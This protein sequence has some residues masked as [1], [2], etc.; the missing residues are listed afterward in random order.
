MEDTGSSSST[1]RRKNYKKSCHCGIKSSIRKA[2]TDKNPGRLFYGCDRYQEDGCNFFEWYDDG[3]VTGWPK[4]S[5]L[6][7]RDELRQKDR[8]I[9]RLRDRV[10]SLEAELIQHR[11]Q[12]VQPNAPDRNWKDTIFRYLCGN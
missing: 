1:R 5:L 2:W 7:A 9:R 10:A 11:H 6:E 4:R 12:D 8:E 3:E